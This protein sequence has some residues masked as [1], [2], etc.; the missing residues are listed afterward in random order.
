MVN[1]TNQNTGQLLENAAFSGTVAGT[2]HHSF[3]GRTPLL[4]GIHKWVQARSFEKTVNRAYHQFAQKHEQ[5]VD[6]YFDNYFVKQ[7]TPRL[8]ENYRRNNGLTLATEL[9]DLWADQ[10]APNSS[11]RKH[12]G[13]ARAI[14]G[15]FLGMVEAEL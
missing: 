6:S 10:F 9:A 8:L 4:T 12:T 2:N 15:I 11:F 3:L 1:S 14:A 5:W 7:H 13:E